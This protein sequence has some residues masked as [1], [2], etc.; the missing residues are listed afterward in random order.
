MIYN[1]VGRLLQKY[2]HEDRKSPILW[3]FREVSFYFGPFT[4][5]LQISTFSN[6][7]TNRR[8]FFYFFEVKYYPYIQVGLWTEPCCSRDVYFPTIIYIPFMRRCF[9]TFKLQIKNITVFYFCLY[10]VSMDFYNMH[11]TTSHKVPLVHEVD[12]SPNK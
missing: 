12:A 10:R 6:F 3:L 5:A 8:R 1:L 9:S 11:M 2:L 7:V 4:F